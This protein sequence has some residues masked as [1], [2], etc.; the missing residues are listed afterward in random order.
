MNKILLIVLTLSFITSTN[1]QTDSIL[2][3]Q[4]GPGLNDGTDQGGISG[5]KDVYTNEYIPSQNF[6]EDSVLFTLPISNCNNTQMRTFI[7]FDLTYLPTIVDSVFV[8][9]THKQ[10][11]IC[12]SNCVADFY[13]AAINQ[14]WD[15]TVVNYSNMPTYGAS[16]YGPINISVPNNYGVREYDIT[17]MYNQWKNG[18]VAYHGF[19]IYSTTVGCNNG[20][21]MF[22][23]YS[24]DDTIPAN[25][26]YLKIYFNPEN[27]PTLSDSLSAHYPFNGNA[28]DE[29]GNGNDGTVN[30]ATLVADRFGNPN[31]A[32][33]FN[34]ID[35]LIEIAN[36]ILPNT[37]TSYSISVWINPF[38]STDGSII[39]DR[40]SSSWDYKY[41]MN[42]NP[43]RLSTSSNINTC[44][45]STFFDSQTVNLNTWQHLTVTLN[46]SDNTIKSYINGSLVDSHNGFCWPNQM[47][48]TTIGASPNP[49]GQIDYYYNGIIDDIRIYKRVL[50]QSEI[51]A[52][53]NENQCRIDQSLTQNNNILTANQSGA[54]YQWLD[55]DNGYTEMQGET[56]QSFTATQNGNYAVEITQGVCVDTSACYS[57]S[58]LGILENNLGTDITVYPNPTEGMV[59]IDLG[60]ALSEFNVSIIDGNGKLIRQSTYNNTKMFELNLDVQSG[61][62]L[63]TINSGNKKATIRLMKN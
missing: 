61:I 44:V 16:F 40:S 7:Q 5:G 2:I 31:S 18:T 60:E 42:T 53:F 51:E 14:P 12:W 63:L 3:F 62:Y 20:C 29:S 27:Q 9:F 11:T 28:N 21:A 38:T 50:T 59:K 26:P 45:N 43:L 10:H 39:G 56:N 6:A 35:N 52:L 8:G 30:G 47:T 33:S 13:F 41:F 15:E 49:A 55:C 37:P 1:A 17:T 48:A 22:A 32:Y 57:V 46:T 36:S 58:S 19:A 34:G 24:S 23:A 25:R 54:T 4:P